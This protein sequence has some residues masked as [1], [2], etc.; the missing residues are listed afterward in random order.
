MLH[1]YFLKWIALISVVV[2]TSSFKVFS[3]DNWPRFRG[4]NG[5]GISDV[6]TVP[7]KWGDKNIHWRFPL[8]GEGNASPVVWENQ[9]FVTAADADRGIRSLYA[10]DAGAGKENWRLD[11]PFEKYRK[12]KNNSFASSTPA[13]DELHVYAVWQS[14]QESALVAVTHNGEKQWSYDLGPRTQG[15]GGAASPIVYGEWVIFPNDHQKGSF[16]VAVDRK[17]GDEAWKIPRK[18]ERACFTTPCVYALPGRSPE[19]IFTH[20]YEGITGVD[21]ATGVTNWHIDVFGTNSQRAIGSPVISNDLV[22]GSSGAA[23]GKRNIVAVRPLASDVQRQQPNATAEEIYRVFKSA[24]HVP[25]PIV[26]EGRLYLWEDKGVVTAHDAASGEV[27]WRQRIGGNYFAS[28]VIVDNRLL[29]MDVTGAVFVVSLGDD[30]Q[31][32]AKNKLPEGGKASFAVGAGLLFARTEK[33][34]YAIGE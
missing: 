17:T 21:P 22:I 11:F 6:K 29:N 26:H 18:G 19:I 33:A 23:G 28:P 31:I 32:L 9:V 1:R 5:T 16:L 4:P 2:T 12:H 10:I 25:S 34:L 7:S 13:V 30:P 8:P 3:E 20:C 15:Q 14:P 24:P 27:I